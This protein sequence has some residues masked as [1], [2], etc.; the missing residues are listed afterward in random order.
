M[1]FLHFVHHFLFFFI[2]FFSHSF[3]TKQQNRY[4]QGMAVDWLVLH[5]L[6]LRLYAILHLAMTTLTLLA[7]FLTVEHGDRGICIAEMRIKDAFVFQ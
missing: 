4:S 2:F 6:L 3:S 7:L 5:V 1:A